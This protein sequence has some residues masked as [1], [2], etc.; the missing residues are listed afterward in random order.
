MGLRIL[1]ELPYAIIEHLNN[2]AFWIFEWKNVLKDYKWNSTCMC[3]CI[4][5][6]KYIPMIFKYR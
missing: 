2:S 5:S 3:R 4:M 6:G 1:E